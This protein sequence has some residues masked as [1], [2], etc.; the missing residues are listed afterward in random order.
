MYVFEISIDFRIGRFENEY[1][2]I[3]S[4]PILAKSHL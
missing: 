4:F 1:F 3:F 2:E